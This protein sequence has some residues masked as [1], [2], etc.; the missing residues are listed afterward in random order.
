MV[1]RFVQLIVLSGIFSVLVVPN[2]LAE[3]SWVTDYRSLE[4]NE[5]QTTDDVQS[6][7]AAEI[8]HLNDIEQPATTLDEWIAQIAQAQAQ[9]TGVQVTATDAGL[10]IT[11]ETSESLKSP[12]TSVVGNALIADI[13]NAVLAL[14]D[15]AEF[16]AVNPAAGIT[17]VSVTSLPNNR[18]RVAITG[19]DA[20]PVAEVRTEAQNFVLSITLEAGE[21]EE[22]AIE[23]IVTGEQE[24]DYR[25]PNASAATRTDVPI[26][27][28]PQSIQVIPQQVL[29]DQGITQL[30]EALR[31]ISG[32]SPT[33]RTTDAFGDYFT[34]RGFSS[35]RVFL[36]DGFRSPF[37]GNNINLESANVERL[38]VLRGPASVLYGQAEPGGLINLVTEQPSEEPFY[39][40]EG[41]IGS[42]DFYR[43]SLDLTGPLNEDRTI[44]YRLNLA[45]QNSG[46][47][48]DFLD[49]ERFFVAP[50]MSIQLG[51]NTNL[52]LEGQY[53]DNT[54]FADTGLPV[55]GTVLP[56]PVGEIP[57]SRFVGEPDIGPRTRRLGSVGYR[58]EHELSDRWSLRNAFRFDFLDTSGETY[59]F[60]DG[61]AEDN[62]TLNRT[63]YQTPE[64]IS[65]S[66]AVL[67]DIRGSINSGSNVRHDLLFGLEFRRVTDASLFASAPIDPIDVFAP[68]YGASLGEFT[69]SS[70]SISRQSIWG[71]YLQNLIRIGNNFNI[72]LGARYDW[73]NQVTRD[74]LTDDYFDQQDTALTP[75]VGVVYQLEPISLYTSYARSFSPIEFGQRNA[76]GTPFEPTTGEQFEV[77][78]KTELFGGKLAATLVAYQ[79]TQQNLITPDPNQPNFSIQ[80]G[81]QRSRGIELDVVGQPLPGLNLIATYAYTDAELTRDNSGNEGNQASNVP[82]HS[83]SLW[84][85]YEI[86]DGD[87]EGLGFGAG[88]FFVGEQQGDL[89]NT[90]TLPSYIRTDA[91]IYYRRDN[92]RIALNVKNLFDVDYFRSSFG[93]NNVFYGDPFTILGTASVTF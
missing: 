24:D 10:D 93:R 37:G 20:P 38:E 52:V 66:Y 87:L 71:I 13:P 16:Q 70:D 82:E 27:D 53:L 15:G 81:E 29:E 61:L 12:S 44:L 88:V 79:I 32:I 90:F 41:Q 21:A 35:G 14:P 45:Y 3:E 65:E 55:V 6:S 34:I 64:G 56:N 59:V 39:E 67:T 25:V 77:G 62:R 22:D 2:V 7:S 85:T 30:G 5:G 40:L 23:I 74:A 4:R 31:N 54:G 19:V 18:V 83:A 75:R 68:N 57:R 46:T 63:A 49:I 58:L 69:L 33:A 72:L 80:V 8:P 43:P 89:A 84:A 78:I 51:E 50:V 28:T 26:R 73:V 42:Y 76:D 86:Q 47:F 11:L 48:V 36:V 60:P 91:A 1:N 9:V 17:L 92:W